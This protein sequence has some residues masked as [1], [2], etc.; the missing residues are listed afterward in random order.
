[1]I[2]YH[3]TVL[4]VDDEVNI[5]NSLKRLF[6]KERF[7]FLTASSGAEA[8]N[9]MQEKEVNVIIADQKM[10]AMSGTELMARVKDIYPD[11]IRIILTGYTD[12]DSISE[13]VN[14]GYIYKFFMKPWNDQ[15][16]I[17]EVRQAIEQYDLIKANRVLHHKV[18]EQNLTLQQ[19]NENLEN[20]VKERTRE[21]QIKNHALA[22]SHAVLEDLPVPII[23]VSD[24]LLIVL[25]NKAVQNDLEIENRMIG[26]YISDY[27]HESITEKIKE[28]IASGKPETLNYTFSENCLKKIIITPLSGEFSEKGAILTIT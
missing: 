26:C 16:L 17:L 15:A 27:L 12:V 9:L 7:T 6:R 21:I 14:K 22:L 4:C 19:I 8:L 23:G 25:I 1:M 2:S 3:N 10:P 18:L 5:L 13:S 28:S 24:E 11:I 20:I